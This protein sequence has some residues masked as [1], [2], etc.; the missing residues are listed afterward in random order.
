M[1][2]DDRHHPLLDHRR[3][4]RRGRLGHVHR[5]FHAHHRFGVPAVTERALVYGVAVAGLATVRA[6]VDRNVDVVA[7]DDQPSPTKSSALAAMGVELRAAPDDVELGSLIAAC[8]VVVPAP[9]VPESHRVVL[10]AQKAGRRIATE[11]DLAYDWESTRVGGPRPIVA[12]TGTD[13]KTTTTLLAAAMIQSAGR[14]TVACGNT[15]VPMVEAL[16]MDVDC[17]VVEATS[18]RLAFTTTFRA[19]AA[20]WLNLAP[21]HLDWHESMK[22][23]ESAKA[24]LWAHVRPSDTAIGWVDDPIVMRHL[25]RAACRRVTFGLDQADYKLVDASLMGPDGAIGDVASMRRA[26]PHDITNAL[27]ASALVIESGLADVRAI[28]AAL[29][30]FEAPH[31]RIEFVGMHDDISWYDDSKATTPHA[32]RTALRG[33]GNVVL[34]AGGRN[35]GLDLSPIADESAR[36]R[37]VVAIGDAADEIAAVFA[38]RRPVEHASSMSEAVETARRLARSGDTVLLSPGCTSFDWYDGYARRGEDFTRCVRDLMG[39]SR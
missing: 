12:V 34:I 10:A 31:H 20:A 6:L 28:G 24:R 3:Y 15:E 11:L 22:T 39:V 14:A 7:V 32:V 35:K 5:R 9:G 4:L 1:A 16:A 13:G 21:D 18:F 19:D 36:I 30:D 8:D 33:F 29:G 37:A 27:C 38:G 2:R 25:G 23:Y 17:F 26:L